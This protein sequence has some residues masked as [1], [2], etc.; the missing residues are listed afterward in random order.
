MALLQRFR[1]MLT[2]ILVKD[3]SK[4]DALARELQ[5]LLKLGDNV[6]LSSLI[7]RYLGGNV[8]NSKVLDSIHLV[9][10]GH[11]ID[12]KYPLYFLKWLEQAYRAYDEENLSK[13]GKLTVRSLV[14]E[15]REFWPAP[16]TRKG[17][18][19]EEELYAHEAAAYPRYDAA[20]HLMLGIAAAVERKTLGAS[21]ARA[22]EGVA[23]LTEAVRLFR[24]LPPRQ[25]AL[26]T[27]DKFHMALALHMIDWL[28]TEY[29]SEEDRR[30]KLE[31]L[32]TLSALSA[33]EWVADQTDSWVFTYNVTEIYGAIKRVQDGKRSLI[34]GI[35]LNP[36]LAAFD[37]ETKS[38]GLDEPLSAAP[39]LRDILTA[40]TQEKSEWLSMRK[41]AYQQHA[42]EYERSPT[43]AIK[44]M[45]TSVNGMDSALKGSKLKR[46][47]GLLCVALLAS[48]YMFAAHPHP[49]R[50]V[51]NSK[52]IFAVDVQRPAMVA[53][54]PIFGGGGAA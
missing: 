4:Q 9:F 44:A 52:P 48:A 35:K 53:F 49:L 3:F 25:H 54:K 27:S 51:S 18:A 24:E 19:S 21:H 30:K 7:C 11:I 40:I 16:A 17:D 26:S 14:A 22:R 32:A 29:A 34:K 33:F 46:S 39:A 47:V 31:E 10:W 38:D 2:K 50:L 42:E 8:E 12:R 5:G 37:A 36:R 1:V 15:P 13:N 45:S 41:A 20:R 6:D 23:H 28:L 43:K